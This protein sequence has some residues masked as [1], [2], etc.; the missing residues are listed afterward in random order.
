MINHIINGDIAHVYYDHDR[1]FWGCLPWVAIWDSY[2]PTPIDYDT[3]ATNP[4]GEG[5]T[6]QEALNNLLEQSE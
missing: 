6:E 2:D 4:M 5:L 1:A 3:P